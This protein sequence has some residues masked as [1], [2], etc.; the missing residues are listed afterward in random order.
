MNEAK[1]REIVGETIARTPIEP[2]KYYHVCWWEGRIQCLHVHHT[3]EVHPVFY[4]APGQVFADGLTPRQWQLIVDRVM[5]FC[6]TRN[7]KLAALS[8]RPWGKT[9]RKPGQ[10]GL[11][12][13]EFDSARLRA[14]IASIQSPESPSNALLDRLRRLLESAHTVAPQ[15]VPSD[16][17]TMNS[18][19]RL[20]D[21]EK[22]CEMTVSLVFPLD[23]LKDK[24]DFDEMNVSVLS[25]IGLSIL[26]RRVGDTLDGRIRV[27]R[28]LYQPEAA[29]DF[30]L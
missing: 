7:V 24:K 29:G 6:R 18:Q 28:L 13:T 27:D 15:D 22:N 5:D 20:K 11:Q 26:G 17:V 1:V 25:P 10:G 23:S 3:K 14:M 12:I 19:V 8:A 30:H 21:N 2:W 4:G 9:R 16:V